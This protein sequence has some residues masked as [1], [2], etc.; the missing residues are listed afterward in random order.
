MELGKKMKIEGI[1]SIQK[2]AKIVGIDLVKKLRVVFKIES[3]R[4]N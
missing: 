2:F 1:K 3:N 4:L